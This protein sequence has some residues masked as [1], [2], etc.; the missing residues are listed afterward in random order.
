MVDDIE[1]LRRS[2]AALDTIPEAAT[3]LARELERMR[4][5]AEQL[6]FL[7]SAGEMA[8]LSDA[9]QRA[10]EETRQFNLPADQLAKIS[11]SLQLIS[12]PPEM[13]TLA[14]HAAAQSRFLAEEA[15]KLTECLTIASR[16]RIIPEVPSGPIGPLRRP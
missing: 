9:A 1:Q 4:P 14:N 7:S 3:R 5:T 12:P 6:R 11:K 2:L 8:K 13:V 15:S 16:V 10:L